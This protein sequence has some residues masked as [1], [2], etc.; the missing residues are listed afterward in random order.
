MVH[1]VCEVCQE[2]L[3]KNKLDSHFQDCKRAQY[4]CLDCSTTFQG[5]SYRKHT[6]CISEEQKYQKNVSKDTKRKEPPSSNKIEGNNQGIDSK[7]ARTD[8]NNQAVGIKTPSDLIAKANGSGLRLEDLQEKPQVNKDKNAGKNNSQNKG[9]ELDKLESK[10][11]KSE[12][13][14][15]SIN[16]IEAS[17]V[18]SSEAVETTT[19]TSETEGDE[20]V[21]PL[22]QRFWDAIPER[23]IP[24]SK[25]VKML[26]RKTDKEG[27]TK[28]EKYLFQRLVL[29]KKGNQVIAE[30]TPEK[31]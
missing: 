25:L 19:V 26:R 22:E 8:V 5:D 30:L 17:K 7:K 18:T 29:K 1:F 16:S 24:M 2:T 21:K 31:I 23:G 9:K 27:R 14:N 6:S 12:E 3:R 20:G 13:K 4:T 15:N 11:S 10:I 28:Q